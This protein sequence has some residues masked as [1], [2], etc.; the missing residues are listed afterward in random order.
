MTERYDVYDLDRQR[1]GAVR[2]RGK[3]HPK[4]QCQLVV[5]V[6]LFNDR[7]E[8]LIQRRSLRKK[9]FPGRGDVSVG[10]GVLAGETA[11]E[12]GER[13]VKEELGID[14][15]LTGPAAVTMAF[16]GG[17]DDFFLS[18]WNGELSD[19]TLQAEEVMDAR[20][21]T[22]EEMR[23]LLAEKKMA[24]FWPSFLELLFDLNQHMGLSE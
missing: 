3:K 14:V 23:Q 1:T 6:C 9:G 22:R 7:G 10:G 12:A 15:K 18:H 24:P 17:F 21:A 2:P 8:M 13:E 4:D 11:R 19:L 5:H 20:W 16:E